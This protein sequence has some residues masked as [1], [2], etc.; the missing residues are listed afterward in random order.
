[1]SQFGAEDLVSNLQN[2]SA[3]NQALV[4][5]QKADPQPIDVILYQEC[6]DSQT[7][8]K[9]SRLLKNMPVR[10]NTDSSDAF[11][12]MVVNKDVTGV[13]LGPVR[14][15]SL[16]P[17]IAQI[18]NTE[19]K[20]LNILKKKPSFP[21]TDY[22]IRIPEETIG[23][24]QLSAFNVE[25]NLPAVQQS[26]LSERT[27]TLMAI[28][29]Q[30][31]VSFMAEELAA[32]SPYRRNELQAQI[33]KAMIRMERTMNPLLLSALENT[34]EALPNIPSL[35]GMVTR[36]TV[37]PIAVGGGNLTDALIAQ[38]ITQLAAFFGFDALNDVVA[39]TN[40]TQIPV[41]RNLMINR[42][43]GNEP[44]AKMGYDEVLVKRLAGL[45]L[46]PGDIQMIYEDNNGLAIP[47]IRDMQMPTGTTMFFR[48]SLPQLAKFHMQGKPGSFL[49]ER[50]VTNLYHLSVLF[51][52]ISLCDPLAQSRCLLT[53]HS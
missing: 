17:Y 2:K 43:P 39:L 31:N 15:V 18:V 47:F 6:K 8:E 23:N 50:P 38:A 25:G 37:G 53:G 26:V 13:D 36:S 51:D 1:M 48:A 24:D 42:Y 9:V 10:M 41:I 44:L 29:Q 28:G 12:T 11:S 49:V 5:I 19:A 27:N 35:G 45:G 7:R 20:F 21:A 22:Q 4:P 33:Q 14:I 46:E 40:N 52:L 34:D 30:I 3:G 32:Q 16:Y